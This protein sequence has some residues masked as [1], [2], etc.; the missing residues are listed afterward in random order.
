MIKKLYKRDLDKMTK[1]LRWFFLIS[2]SLAIIT[3]LINIG[4]DI[5]AIKIIGM[6]FS[7]LTYS[8]VA[9]VLINTFTNILIY[10]KSNFYND[11][12]YLTH[13]LPVTKKQLIISKYL[14][15]L[16]VIISSFVV[17]ILSLLIVLYDKTF[18]DFIKTAL[19]MVV[20][21]LDMSVGGFITVIA[22]V[23]FSQILSIMG[24]GF[25]AIVKGNSYNQKKALKGVLWFIA[26]YFGSIGITL[27]TSVIVFAIGGNLSELSATVMKASSFIT[28]I[29]VGLTL[30]LLYAVYY[31]IFCYKL[32]NR[33]VNVD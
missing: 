6:V 20:S 30:Y 24:M 1:T 28:I 27:I 3:R 8:A 4:K 23:L 18:V 25:S 15:S 19:T 29:V 33:G 2:I 26:Y 14:S 21:G 9:N 12:S 5:Q 31:A 10:F 17:M 16:T 32:F 13:T 7:G 11:E 22:L